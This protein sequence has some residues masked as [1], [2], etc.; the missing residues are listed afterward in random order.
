[1]RFY[2]KKRNY[3]WFIFL[4]ISYSAF[5]MTISE[6][7]YCKNLIYRDAFLKLDQKQGLV[8][9]DSGVYSERFYSVVHNYLQKKGYKN[10]SIQSVKVFVPSKFMWECLIE[11]GFNRSCSGQLKA[12]LTVEGDTKYSGGFYGPFIETD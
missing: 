11:S 3:L 7:I 4:F 9:Q 6:N 8:L 5:A 10:Q 1:M 2:M 12:F